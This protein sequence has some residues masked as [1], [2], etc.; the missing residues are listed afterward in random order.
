M[1]SFG[2]LIDCGILPCV[3]QPGHECKH[4]G[5]DL[6]IGCLD[7]HHMQ[8]NISHIDST[9]QIGAITESVVW[10]GSVSAASNHSTHSEDNTGEFKA[11]H[12]VKAVFD[13]QDILPMDC[14]KHS[15]HHDV[16]M[17]C[18][19]LTK[20]QQSKLLDFFKGHADVFSGNLGIFQG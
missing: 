15:C 19:L 2:P 18:K 16:V 13:K 4:K 10:P 14:D 17:H 20:N 8:V 7:L 11:P 3:D 1:P 12:V 6:I 9:I 5:C